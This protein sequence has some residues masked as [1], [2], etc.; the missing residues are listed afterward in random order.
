V[1]FVVVVLTFRLVAVCPGR[2]VGALG[3]GISA[4]GQPLRLAGPRL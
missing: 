1:V 2:L 4:A 3:V